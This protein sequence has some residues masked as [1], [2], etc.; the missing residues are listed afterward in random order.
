M[1]KQI[2]LR[3]FTIEWVPGCSC[4]LTWSMHL[5]IFVNNAMSQVHGFAL[6]IIVTSLLLVI[7]KVRT[8]FC[9]NAVHLT[10]LLDY[11]HASTCCY[12]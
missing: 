11:D 9:I 4:A 6:I 3:I 12:Y 7:I 5:I 1:R 10:C 8:W 2:L